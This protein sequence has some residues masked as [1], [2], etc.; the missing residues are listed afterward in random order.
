MCGFVGIVDFSKKINMMKGHDALKSLEHRGPDAQGSWSDDHHI[1]LGHN[2]LS[3]IDVS[4]K[5]N[6]PFL[7]SKEDALIVFNGEIYNYMEL[8]KQLSFDSFKTNSDTETILEGYLEKGVEFFKKLRGIYA[9]VIL[10]RRGPGQI[11]MVRDPAGVKPLYYTVQNR[12]IIFAS[13]IKAI[14][15][16]SIESNRINNISIKHYLNLGYIPEPN[17]V[18][19]NIFAVNPGYYFIWNCN[20]NI[21][22]KPFYQY[23]FDSYN[24]LSFKDNL[25]H[26]Y[27][28]IEKAMDR[29][30]V[31][32]V[33][34]SFALSGGIDSSLLYYFANKKDN[35]IIA[36]TI[37]FSKESRYDETNISK[38]Y[39]SR[40]KGNHEIIDIQKK[41]GLE[42]IDRLFLHFDQPFADS[43]AI[44][45]Y[46]ITKN[47]SEYG[48]VIIGGDGGDE[49]FNG[50]P[51]QNWLL[52][53][54]PFS[55]Y[56]RTWGMLNCLGKVLPARNRRQLNRV[57]NLT[58]YHNDI[59]DV[60]YNRN[61]W[62]PLGSKID[63]VNAFINPDIN[64]QLESY[65][66]IF[67][68]DMPEKDEGKILFDYFR[69]KL[70]SDYL[71]K[72]DMMSMLNGVEWRVPFLDEDLSSFAFTIPFNQKSNLITGKKHLRALHKRLYPKHTS[73][74]PKAGFTIPLDSFI[75]KK[76]K[77]RM[78][79]EILK[80]E[81]YVTTF[82]NRSYIELLVE[83]FN[84]YNN[85]RDISRA[86]VYQRV[87]IL[88][89]LQRWYDTK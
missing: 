24:S 41:I 59:M 63:G 51:S 30:L 42:L 85:A 60:M 31:S 58:K 6:Q 11:L 1:Y 37:G 52:R 12:T 26:T 77:K 34:V 8:R 79:N 62:F 76:N 68:Q 65:R 36:K 54:F 15:K 35:E 14:K 46:F 9:F 2:R 55:H 3:I 32:D 82:I 21:L 56:H 39:S 71:R 75:T 33:E 73:L 40:L 67:E 83:Q 84:H 17:T 72:T 49:L 69:K 29:N 13:E 78:A 80:K 4:K 64:E 28:K 89:V 81:S 47:I 57:K 66:H 23:S 50:Y 88:Y 74:K 38:I 44:P 27:Q 16:L 43:S 87:L 45:T 70:L 25:E 48:K 18:Y 19:K 5:A 20:E 7:S 53:F 22:K 86:S 10:D 61:S